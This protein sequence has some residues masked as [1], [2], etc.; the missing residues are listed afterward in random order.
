MPAAD[1]ARGKLI[2]RLLA[3]IGADGV[4]HEPCRSR[5]LESALALPLVRRYGNTTS[6]TRLIS[7]LEDPSHSRDPLDGLLTAA[8]LGS[9]T[10]TPDPGTIDSFTGHVPRF[11]ERRKRATLSALLAACGSPP[12]DLGLDAAAFEVTGLHPWAEVQ[13]TAAKVI[14]AADARRPDLISERDVRLLATTQSPPSV[15]EAD[16]LVSLSVLHALARLPGMDAMVTA[17]VAKV[18]AHQRS[19]GGLPFV[20]DVDTWCTATAGVALA[21]AGAPPADLSRIAATLGRLQRPGGGWSFTGTAELTDADDTAVALE[22]LQHS[23]GARYADVISRGLAALTALRGPDGGFPTYVA[24]A[25]SEA[26]MTA[27]AVNAMATHPQSSPLVPGALD[28]LADQQHKDGTFGPDWS[29]SRLH[30]V[31][32]VILACQQCTAPSERIRRMSE[33]ALRHILATQNPDGGW[34]HQPGSPSDAISTS[35]A[36][37]ALCYQPN[38]EPV[39]QGAQ[40]LIGQQRP[41]GGIDSIPDSIGPRP[42]IFQIPVLADIF[43]LLALAHLARRAPRPTPSCPLPS[44]TSPTEAAAP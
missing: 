37:I 34:G 29:A 26:C 2:A 19:D 27:A 20:T 4:V 3:R 11:T 1:L 22:F 9:Q 36:L 28:F 42:F 18:T 21:C 6:A 35:Y 14:L 13:V 43:A 41:N 17:G 15:W 12:G 23:H 16:I 30:T 31:F 44:A 5:V 8:A 40:Y 24:G 32:R 33:R 10:S 25:T 38:P 7:Y 39:A